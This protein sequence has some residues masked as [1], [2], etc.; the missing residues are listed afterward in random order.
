MITLGVVVRYPLL[1]A[2]K[3]LH[4]IDLA[5]REYL[6]KIT[7]SA[8]LVAAIEKRVKSTR[9]NYFKLAIPAALIFSATVIIIVAYISRLHNHYDFLITLTV[10]YIVE[11]LLLYPVIRSSPE[12]WTFQALIASLSKVDGAI[13][14]PAAS[15]ARK[16]LSR[17]I[18]SSSK[19]MQGYRPLLPLRFHKRIQGREAIRASRALRQ[20]VYPAMLGTDEELVQI[21]E[22]L[23]GAALRVGTTNWVQVGDLESSPNYGIGHKRF[24]FGLL[25]PW[26]V[27]VVIPLITALI[28]VLI[29]VLTKSPKS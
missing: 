21:K 2:I 23:A 20:L 26:L 6:I 8:D 16:K 1:L 13:G 29:A 10:V 28:T 22:A 17:M 18:L 9:I 27:G 15:K 3:P 4:T 11:F 25:L 7:G 14:S 24:A 5:Q 19:K 12:Y